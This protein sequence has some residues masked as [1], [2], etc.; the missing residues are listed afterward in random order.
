MSFTDRVTVFVNNATVSETIL[1]A[2]IDPAS[3]NP[4]PIQSIGFSD[5]VTYKV[6]RPVDD[7]T[8]EV[9][10]F[11]D[12]VVATI[13]PKNSTSTGD[14]TKTISE[15]LSF[16]DVVFVTINDSIMV[17]LSEILSIDSELLSG[18]YTLPTSDIISEIQLEHDTIEINK[19]VTWTHDVIFSND[20][21]SVAVEIPA[22]AEILMIKS[23]NDTSETIIFDSKE[24]VQTNSTYSGLYDDADI[25]DK[26]LKK[27]FRLVDS[28][29]TIES[30]I[31]K[32]NEKISYYANLDTAKAHTKLDKLNANLD[33]LENKLENKLEKLSDVVPLASL[34]QVNEML[35]EDKPLKVLVLNNTDPNV[36]LTFTTPA[37]TTLEHDN[38]TND[39]FNKKVTVSHE[40][41][42]HYTNVTAYSALP[43]DLVEADTDFKLFWNIN[44]TRVNVTDDPR[45]AVE[46]VDTDANG[47]VDQMKWIVPQLS[48]QEFDIEA[49]LEIINVQSYPAVGGTWKVRFTTN[50]TSDLV[51]SA[52]N[53]TT[54]G[55]VSPDDLKFL[56][57]NNGTHKL[58]PVVN[59][60]T[61]T[62]YNYSSTEEGF[63][64]SEVLTPFKHHLMFQFGNKTAF[65]HN[66]AFVPNGPKVILL[67]GDPVVLGSPDTED[68][69]AVSN[70]VIPGWDEAADR[71]DSIFTHDASGGGCNGVCR[72]LY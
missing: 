30:K 4:S 62:Y 18:N 57:L 7:S 19:Q 36:E 43:E 31:N 71:T 25:S 58:Y 3:V 5:Y 26:D 65:A 21:E 69:L 1:V 45:F 47:I 67:H 20:T 27:Y 39:T 13:V 37:P 34:Q 38:S 16:T 24:F 52:V 70:A 32:T 40:S 54:F 10:A 66:S 48:E 56:E 9:V 14:E 28:V 23:L 60:N 15:S 44:N 72:F 2:T 46:F 35:Q 41:A 64:E 42:L 63:E 11:S 29:Q 51:I 68:D 6:I 8:V 50:G 59:G 22:D 17:S 53:G 33:K 61:I 55:T 12:V 49:D